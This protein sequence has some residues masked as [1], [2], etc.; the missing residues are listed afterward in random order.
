MFGR[1]LVQPRALLLEIQHHLH[2]Q[3]QVSRVEKLVPADPRPWRGDVCL[4]LLLLLNSLFAQ[5]VSSQ[6]S[7]QGWFSGSSLGS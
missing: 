2:R 6:E 1:V 5:P 7:S 3:G 4:E